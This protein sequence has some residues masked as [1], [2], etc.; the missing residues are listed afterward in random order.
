MNEAMQRR[1]DL[2]ITI[3]GNDNLA[4]EAHIRNFLNS[5]LGTEKPIAPP[6]AGYEAAIPGFL[7]VM[8]Y[9]QKKVALWDNKTDSYKMS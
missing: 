7:S 8:S 2:T 1:K 4:V 6:Q 3:P 5:V 9:K